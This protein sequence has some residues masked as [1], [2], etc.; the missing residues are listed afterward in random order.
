M[1]FLFVSVQVRLDN[2]PTHMHHKFAVIDNR[3]LIN[4]SFNWTRQAVIGN[5]ENV[6]V[7]DMYELRQPFIAEFEKLWHE[8]QNNQLRL[9]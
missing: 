4:G 2:S 6:L 7:T 1:F 3:Y 5:R 8:Y 9:S